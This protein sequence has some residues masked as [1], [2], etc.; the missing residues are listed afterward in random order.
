MTERARLEKIRWRELSDTVRDALSG[1][2]RGLYGVQ[3]SESAFDSLAVD[4][5]QALLLL[6]RRLR[7]LSLWE[8][9][10]RVENVYGEG[11]VGMNFIAWPVLRSELR[12]RRDFTSRFAAHR[13]NAAGFMERGRGLGSLHFLYQ[14]EG[15][16]RVWGVHFDLYNPWSSPLNAGRHLFYEKMRGVTPDWRVIGAALRREGKL[17]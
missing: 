15:G 16:Q 14:P 10:R 2:I 7:E 13:Q 11:G 9:V 17:Y 5:Q 4:K 3:S 6:M 8:P 12:R 1:K